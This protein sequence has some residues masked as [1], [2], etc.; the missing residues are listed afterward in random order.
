MMLAVDCCEDS[1]D[2]HGDDG[3]GG[4]GEND[5]GDDDSGDVCNGGGGDDDIGDDYEDVDGD[6]GNLTRKFLL[7]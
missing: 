2:G 7:S 6:Y 1:D 3:C 4:C 5:D